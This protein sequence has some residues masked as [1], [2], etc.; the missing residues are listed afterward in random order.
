MTILLTYHNI[1]FRLGRHVVV[2]FEASVDEIC[3]CTTG[4]RVQSHLNPH[5]TTSK[6][7]DTRHMALLHQ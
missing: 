5:C 3:I 6:M 7:H 1:M 4:T 2:A